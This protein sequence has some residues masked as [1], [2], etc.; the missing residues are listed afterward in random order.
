LSTA[1]FEA[2]DEAVVA[3]DEAAEESVVEAE[4]TIASASSAVS[5]VYDHVTSLPLLALWVL[6][7]DV[8]VFHAVFACMW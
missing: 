4:G 8:V 6:A 7:A 3:A 1:A 2:I 5:W